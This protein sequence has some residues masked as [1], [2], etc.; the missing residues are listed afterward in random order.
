[1]QV[2][3]IQS[4]IGARGAASARA[5][6][7]ARLE[8]MQKE[9]QALGGLQE[10]LADTKKPD[11]TIVAVSPAEKTRIKN[12][13]LKQAEKA[14]IKPH[15]ILQ[16]DWSPE[17][18]ID[19]DHLATIG[20]GMLKQAQEP[21][22]LSEGQA[23]FDGRGRKI[24][25]QGAGTGG[26]NVKGEGELRKEFEGMQKDYR[27]VERAKSRIE[28]AGKE[29]SAAGDIALV[30]SYMKMLDPG[31]TVRESEYATAQNAAGVPD[32]IRAKWNKVKDGETLAPAQRADFL[33]Q[34]DQIYR[35]AT[36][37][38]NQQVDRYRGYAVEYGYNPDRIIKPVKIY[39]KPD[40]PLNPAE[41][42]AVKDARPE[43]ASPRKI[44]KFDKDG[45]LVE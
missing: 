40:N 18:D 45:K 2:Q 29:P 30:F 24:A 43:G 32:I 27:E 12:M 15:P 19:I 42:K 41:S 6:A 3:N 22:T 25:E 23:R 39:D 9:L 21:F 28:S 37:G 31:S 16:G 8:M 7:T 17:M 13:Y 38:F 10:A 35:A 36:E 5:A 14:G 4:E 33:N 34:S 1:M 20:A 44:L 26:A 11:G